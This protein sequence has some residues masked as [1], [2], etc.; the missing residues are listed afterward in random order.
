M[1]KRWTAAAI[2]AVAGALTGYGALRLV[3]LAPDGSDRALLEA[4]DAASP[5]GAITTVPAASRF[6]NARLDAYLSA[7][8]L[9][10]AAAIENAVTRV[11]DEASASPR[12]DVELEALLLRLLEIDARRAIR[13]AQTI[14]LDER[15]VALMLGA[16][17]AYD[18]SA[19]LSALEEI[20]DDGLRRRGALAL[21]GQVVT[22]PEEI[23]RL[24]AAAG[25]GNV[26]GFF[27]DALARLASN[28]P[29]RAFEQAVV[30]PDPA[31]RE[32]AVERIA[33]RWAQLD[34]PAALDAMAG[35]REPLLRNLFHVAVVR[36][37]ASTDPDR[38]LAYVASVE[39]Q[40]LIAMLPEETA[41]A[42]MTM[43]AIH[44]PEEALAA[45][46]AM[47]GTA[48]RLLRTHALP[49]LVARDLPEML[50]RLETGRL[51]VVPGSVSRRTL[52]SQVAR[53]YARQDALVAFE[54][55]K[56]V[57]RES[58]AEFP[59]I[60]A[61]DI[62]LAEIGRTDFARAVDLAVED[63]DV[64]RDLAVTEANLASVSVGAISAI[65]DKLVAAGPSR[66]ADVA[67]LLALWP[68]RDP[69]GAWRWLQAQTAAL[70]PEQIRSVAAGF[71]DKGRAVPTSA[72]RDLPVEHR[73]EF[74][75]AFAS[76]FARAQP[77]GG[78]DWLQAFRGLPDYDGWATD[79]ARALAIA[80][81]LRTPR[82]AAESPENPLYPVPAAAIVSSLDRPPPQ[83][84]TG[85]A[86]T[87]AR[88][89]PR[90][91]LRWALDLQDEQARQPAVA[92]AIA[93]WTVDDR[94]AAREAVLALP[95]GDLRDRALSAYLTQDVG[96]HA[97]IDERI[98]DAF[99]SAR[100]LEAAI[101]RRTLAFAFA[102]LHRRDP[103]TATRL[104]DTHIDDPAVRQ[105]IRDEI[106]RLS[107]F[108]AV[109][110]DTVFS[111]L[112]P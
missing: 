80:G 17:A 52:L 72:V 78:L 46:R 58:P 81:G 15:F 85:V 3:P 28:D 35:I 109:H 103:E 92:A 107:T 18:P 55:A 110:R 98:L 48:A 12:R 6:A 20:D 106:D 94:A 66:A 102:A 47:R 90:E 5:V 10:N 96:A 51:D 41:A 64:E 65:A 77:E 13:F 97:T 99:S 14:G 70:T 40:R 87:W 69:D 60:S 56:R 104:L 105:R 63:P 89:Q 22:S 36:E 95:R 44:R 31:L 24:A 33:E 50:E 71:A 42:V 54:W 34:A 53:A 83:V 27:V 43:L 21:A 23:A 91:A 9:P 112:A 37:W 108:P 86:E 38:A 61:A 19:A 16:L 111:V 59:P 2:A 4:T 26:E 1:A 67:A 73:G 79:V 39:G 100:A 29:R 11:L 30:L 57:D 32:T 82:G 74:I 25:Q 93:A 76:R 75:T 45:S 84:A 7:A 68:K 88:Q 8:D 62:V 101:G 49:Q